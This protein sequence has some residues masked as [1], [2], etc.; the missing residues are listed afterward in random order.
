MV[1]VC[2]T[3]AIVW[4]LDKDPRL[5]LAAK[6]TLAN[7][8]TVLIVPT[9]VLAEIT[10][11]YARGRINISPAI[12]EQKVLTSINCSVHPLDEEVVTLMPASLDIHDAIIVATALVYRDTRQQP[13]TLITKDNK[14]TQSGLI[15]TLW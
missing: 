13:V 3:H 5:S 2:D 12:V 11:L 4:F 10:H 15:Q 1:Y 7:P 6:N 14:I 9:I 8:N